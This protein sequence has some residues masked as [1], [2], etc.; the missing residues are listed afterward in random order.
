MLGLGA[1]LLGAKPAPRIELPDASSAPPIIRTNARPSARAHRVF[2]RGGGSL[3]WGTVCALEQGGY[4]SVDHVT[5]NGTPLIGPRDPVTMR[6]EPSDW[7]FLGIDPKTLKPG[8]FPEMLTGMAVEI[9]GFP[10]RDRDGEVIPGRVYTNDV[11]PPFIWVELQDAAGGIEAEG[12]VG[13]LSGS[14]VFEATTG[15]L[16]AVTHANGFSRIKG[17]T[18]TWA[19]VVPLR[20]AILEAQGSPPVRAAGFAAVPRPSLTEGRWALSLSPKALPSTSSQ[21]KE[22]P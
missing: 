10:A 12:V 2:Y 1:I 17:T 22:M 6:N 3:E 18:N 13:G 11:S 15:R 9:H 14:C 21:S 7:S 16:V 5:T 20:A 8:D 19:L 4:V